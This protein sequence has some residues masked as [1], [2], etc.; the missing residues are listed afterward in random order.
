M[1]LINFLKRMPSVWIPVFIFACMPLTWAKEVCLLRQDIIQAIIDE[2]SGE[3]ALQN[4]IMLAPYE[5]IRDRE[6]FTTRFWE[7]RYIQKKAIEYGLQD[8]RLETFPSEDMLWQA[9]AGE[10][11]LLEPERRKLVD[12][13]EIAASLAIGSQSTDIRAELVYLERASRSSDYE[14]KNVSGKIILTADAVEDAQ[15]IGVIEKQ[16]AGV[17]SYASYTP[18]RHV[19]TVG[20]QWGVDPE[21]KKTGGAPIFGFSISRRLAEELKQMLLDG[22]KVAVQARIKTHTYPG[23]DEVVTAILPGRDLKEEEFVLV[24]HLFEGINKQGA[25]DNNSGSACILEVGRCLTKLI[26]EGKIDTPRRTIRFLWVPEYSG[27]IKFLE[28]HPEIAKNM[29]CGINMDMVGCDLYGNNSPFHVYRSPHSLPGYINLVAENILDFTVNTNRISIE[30]KSSDTIVAPSGSRQNFMCW[31]E[32]FDSESDSDVFNNRQVRVPMVFFC[33]W[34]DDFYH[35]SED[36]PK[37]S[38]ATQL[39]RAGF[40]GTAITY[41]VADAGEKGVLHIVADSVSRIRSRLSLCMRKAY[42]LMSVSS[43]GDTAKTYKRCKNLI[44]QNFRMEIRGLQSCASL[45]KNSPSVIDTIARFENKILEEKEESLAEF[46]RFYRLFCKMSQIEPGEVK[47]TEKEIELAK[48][49]PV[50]VTE[51]IWPPIF[52]VGQDLVIHTITNA[53]YEAFNFIDGKRSILDIAQALDAEF[54]DQAEIDPETVEEFIEALVEANLV[55]IRDSL[56][57]CPKNAARIEPAS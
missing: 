10:L 21:E 30:G 43:P 55:A 11:W 45:A 46:D 50:V 8:V 17:I 19:H 56:Q 4:E 42:N 39:K 28:K 5:R 47:P 2:V 6:E 15:R 57:G 52:E 36:V 32:E 26:R 20:W 29:I 9:E 14:G 44:A 35:S 37:N 13:R 38:D 7:T 48:L 24:A 23:R 25:N 54:I 3:I 49:Y 27:T 22:E 1:R 31:M 40:M 41:A 18:S 51:K 12:I 34:T 33:N 16:A 53:T